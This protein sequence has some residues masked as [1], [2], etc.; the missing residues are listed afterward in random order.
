MPG[1]AI[2]SQPLEVQIVEAVKRFEIRGSD[3]SKLVMLSLDNQGVVSR[4]RRMQFQYTVPEATFDFIEQQA[5][6]L[7]V[8][9][10]EESNSETECSPEEKG[11]QCGYPLPS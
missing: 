1:L 4:N 6:L 8:P 10:V 11:D 5:R 3:V 9:A 2:R 7:L